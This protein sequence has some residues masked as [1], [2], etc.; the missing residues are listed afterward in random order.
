MKKYFIDWPIIKQPNKYLLI[1]KTSFK[2][3]SMP[4]MFVWIG[5]KACC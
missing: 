4:N 2:G 1:L 5:F 3:I